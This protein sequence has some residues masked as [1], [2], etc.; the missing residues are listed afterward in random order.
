[1]ETADRGLQCV[2][3]LI[4]P[5][6]QELFR[7]VP[8]VFGDSAAPSLYTLQG[9]PHPEN[10]RKNLKS[11]QSPLSSSISTRLGGRGSLRGHTPSRKISRFHGLLCPLPSSRFQETTLLS[12]DIRGSPRREKGATSAGSFLL[13]SLQRRTWW[14]G[15]L[16]AEDGV[17]LTSPSQLSSWLKLKLPSDRRTEVRRV[18]G[19]LSFCQ[20]LFC[21]AWETLLACS[22]RLKNFPFM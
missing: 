16:I 6:F 21:R 20:A 17:R 22:P 12:G 7:L 18:L 4:F 5:T 14:G 8:Q 11:F 2:F 1:M 10:P 3:A 13:Q 15:G 19:A 9:G